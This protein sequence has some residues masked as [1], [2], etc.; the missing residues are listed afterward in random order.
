V[1]LRGSRRP[2]ILT[3]P[4]AQFALASVIAVLVVG[5]A[6]L[7]WLRHAARADAI[8]DAE[9]VARLAGEGIVQPSVT[10]ALLAGHPAALARMD[11]L[12]RSKIL[13]REGVVRVKMWTADGRI[14]YSDQRSLIGRRF[15]VWAEDGE[16]MASGRAA[17]QLTQLDR[18]D[19]Q[20]ERDEGRLFE[21]YMPI[22][23]TTGQPLLF[24][25]YQRGSAIATDMKTTWLAS[26]PA[27][28]AALALL[29]LL[30]LPLAHRLSRQLQHSRAEREALLTRAIAASETE[31]RRI[32]SDLHDGVVPELAGT[33]YTL[34][35]AADQINGDAPL[36]TAD[37]L[38][39][40]AHQ[41]RRTIR[42]L[43]SL[44]V[45]IYPPDLHRAGLPAALSDLAAP[46]QS[47]GVKA[48]LQ[49]SPIGHL[50]PDTEA[51]LFRTAHEALRNVI[52]HSGADRVEVGLDGR[53]GQVELRIADDGRGFSPEQA[54]AA[55]DDG[56]LGLRVL[57]DSAQNAGGE[58][59]LE[60]QPGHGTRLR[61][62]LPVA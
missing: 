47:R 6:G 4:L 51:L 10:P 3:V 2:R 5:G 45:D 30:H 39:A 19:N 16:A 42:Q 44:L 33:S 61:L 59:Q 12:V 25:V 50:T 58:L 7:A 32:A 28:V 22:H 38:R 53:D 54:Q 41:T 21:V 24:E 27:L 62:R 49:L 55:R 56:H 23:A 26:V 15:P 1:H 40:A 9:T 14:V 35:A 18:A 43:R 52:A 36:E 57:A 29:G 60:S 11:R 20:F 37:T 17:A 31:R 34:S 8:K 46:L 48:K 13:N